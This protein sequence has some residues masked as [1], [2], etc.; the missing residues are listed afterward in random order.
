[1]C[2]GNGALLRVGPFIIARRYS[3]E[4]YRAIARDMDFVARIN[5]TTVADGLNTFRGALAASLV[6][7]LRMHGRRRIW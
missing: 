4:L 3:Y 7:S 6:V 2:A 5:G 1:M